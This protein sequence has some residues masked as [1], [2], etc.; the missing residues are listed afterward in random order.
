MTFIPLDLQVQLSVSLLLAVCLSM[1]IGLN[2]ERH[3]RPAGLRTHM[4]VCTGSCLFT[5]LSIYAFP[6]SDPA[7]LASQI[8]PGIGFIGAGAIIKDNRS[9]SGVTTAAS[10]WTTAAIG[11][12]VGVGAWFLALVVTIIIWVVLVLVR[13]IEN[14][15]NGSR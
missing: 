12:A 15:S 4:L 3:E 9:V 7:R 2:R 14:R 8:L 11:V 6:G 13:R 10:I 5:L 1:V